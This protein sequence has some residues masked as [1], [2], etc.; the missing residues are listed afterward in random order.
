[1]DRSRVDHGSE[2]V[3]GTLM[4]MC[5][6][7]RQVRMLEPMRLHHL[8][9]GVGCWMRMAAG[10]VVFERC[11]GRGPARPQAIGQLGRVCVTGHA[12]GHAL[13]TFKNLRRPGKTVT[14]QTGRHQARSRGMRGVQLFGVSGGAQKLPQPGGLR[15]GR[16]EGVLHL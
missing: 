3:K 7:P 14:G 16:S 10:S 4:H 9:Q 11:L 15:A 1:M 6:H 5:N 2:Y 12:G 13:R 8:Q